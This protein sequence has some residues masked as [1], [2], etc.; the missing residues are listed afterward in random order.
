MIRSDT[1]HDIES[2][3]RDSAGIHEALRRSVADAVRRHVL[4][5][6]QVPIWLDGRVVWI[7]PEIGPEKTEQ[8]QAE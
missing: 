5:G 7:T 2:R 6:R 3:I 1:S 4:C 8:D